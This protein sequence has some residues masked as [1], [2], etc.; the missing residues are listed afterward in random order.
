MIPLETEN[1]SLIIDKFHYRG[2]LFQIES[3][4]EKFE[5]LQEYVDY[6]NY[7]INNL[8]KLHY[9]QLEK[10]KVFCYR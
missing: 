6:Y 5:N 2:K 3:N 10:F 8:H 1:I 4:K 9:F 7:S